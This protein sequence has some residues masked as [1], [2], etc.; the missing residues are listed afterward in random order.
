MWEPRL[1][2]TLWAF[3]ACLRGSFTFLPLRFIQVYNLYSTLSGVRLSPLGTAATIGLLY[4][5]QMIY[6]GD[7]GAI[8]GMKIGRGNRST[9][10]KPSAVPLC[11]PQIP[12]DLTRA[13]IRTSAMGNQRLTAWAMA[14]PYPSVTHHYFE[15]CL[16]IKSSIYWTYSETSHSDKFRFEWRDF[17]SNNLR[18]LCS[19]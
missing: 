2:T 13:Q 9:R 12:Y 11:L 18:D 16:I 7:C 5:S 14:R 4:Q 8:G 3:T 6:D 10:R 19:V 1:L 15:S 17:H